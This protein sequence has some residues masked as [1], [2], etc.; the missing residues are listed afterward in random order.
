MNLVK[1]VAWNLGNGDRAT[2]PNELASL[3]EAVA[4]AFNELA[5]HLVDLD[6]WADRRHLLAVVNPAL[7]DGTRDV[8]R[9]TQL[10]V[11]PAHVKILRYGVEV[12][13]V[14]WRGPKG[15]RIAGRSIV[16][17]HV[18]ID[19]V[20][21]V[22]VAVHA[23]W[24]PLV[25]RKAWRAYQETLRR[26]GGWFPSDDMLILG[27]QNQSWAA[28]T[29]F[30][31][32]GT[33]NVIRARLVP[34]GGTVDFGLFRPGRVRRWSVSARKGLRLFSDHAYIVYRLVAR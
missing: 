1:V 12:V 18:E 19:G 10:Y 3:P 17:A 34:G 31:I 22:L 33:A 30:A 25:N 6:R 14:P 20:K 23:P 13:E 27:D 5:G 32:R 8:V 21:I 15:K 26:I 9:N 4:Y 7:V 16:W 11:D 24:G 28:R 29:A 2:F